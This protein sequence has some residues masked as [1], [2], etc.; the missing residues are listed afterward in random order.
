MNLISRLAAPKVRSTRKPPRKGRL[1]LSRSRYGFD[2]MLCCTVDFER[3]VQRKGSSRNPFY[4]VNL[5]SWLAAPK[6]RS[7]RKPPRKGWLSLSRS[8]YGFD[9][10]LCCAV[11][12]ERRVQKTEVHER[13]INKHE[14]VLA[15][16][17]STG[18][19]YQRERQPP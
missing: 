19:Y 13:R 16:L 8:R 6:V 4:N 3:R 18:H 5:I 9:R 14:S 12:F 1:S 7:K 2:R 10:M 11:D 17:L 15:K